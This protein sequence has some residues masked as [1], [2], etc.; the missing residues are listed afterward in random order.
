MTKAERYYS[1]MGLGSFSNGNAEGGLTTQEEKSPGAYTK[2]GD[3]LIAG[4]ILPTQQTP[5]PGLW[6]MDVVPDGEPR[7]GYPNINDSS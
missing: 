6:W 5:F 2:S 1:L 4:V 7:F 3:A